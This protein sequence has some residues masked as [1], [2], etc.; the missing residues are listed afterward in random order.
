MAVNHRGR[1]PEFKVANGEGQGKYHSH[2]PDP[3]F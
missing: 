3:E 2:V 1:I